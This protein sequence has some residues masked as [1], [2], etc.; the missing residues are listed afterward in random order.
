MFF[1]AQ[2]VYFNKPF[3][4]NSVLPNSKFHY[5]AKTWY[6]VAKLPWY[7]V[8]GLI[9]GFTWYQGKYLKWWVKVPWFLTKHLCG[10]C[11]II[12]QKY[13]ISGRTPADIRQIPDNGYVSLNLITSY[14]V[15]Y[16]GNYQVK[17]RFRSNTSSLVRQ[18]SETFCD[19]ASVTTL[20]LTPISYLHSSHIRRRCRCLRTLTSSSRGKGLR[21]TVLERWR[22]KCTWKVS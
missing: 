5:Y 10:K 7:Q 4:A 17:I 13:L 19:V 20:D 14:Q 22:R 8:S 9:L 21:I 18:F 3:I 2:L 12:R 6:Q 1:W 11:H 16:Q 15:R